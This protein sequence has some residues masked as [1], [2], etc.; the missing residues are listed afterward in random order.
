MSRIA[1]VGEGRISSALS[2]NNLDIYINECTNCAH[3]CRVCAEASTVGGGATKFSRCIDACLECAK[4]CETA[5]RALSIHR[6][7]TRDISTFQ[8]E[9][10]IIACK[11]CARTCGERGGGFE[12]FAVCA[13]ASRRCAEVISTLLSHKPKPKSLTFLRGF[14]QREPAF[15]HR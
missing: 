3:T 1:E 2:Q 7:G 5:A 10:C 11:L 12:C 4:T 13:E 14:V 9:A 8:L 15:S 6:Q